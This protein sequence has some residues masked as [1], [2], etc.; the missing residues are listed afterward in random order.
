[1]IHEQD[2]VVVEDIASEQQE[3]R[4]MWHAPELRSAEMRRETKSGSAGN[5]DGSSFS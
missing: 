3:K 2:T 1:M 4:K 5:R